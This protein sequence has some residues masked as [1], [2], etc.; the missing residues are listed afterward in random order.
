MSTAT[1]R[2]SESPPRVVRET[3]GTCPVCIEMVDARVIV[4]EGKVFLEKNCP[5]HGIKR[6]FLSN[7]PDYYVE[8]MEAFFELM[9][10]S[11]PQRDYILRL[12]ARCN[13]KCPICLASADDYQERDMT[14]EEVREFIDQPRRLKLDL[15]GAEPTLWPD[16]ETVIRESKEKGH[17]NALHSNGIRLLD[18]DY[19][20]RLIDAGEIGEVQSINLYQS[21]NE[22]SGGGCQGLSVLRLFAA[23]VDWVTGW[24]QGDPTDDGTRTWGATSSSPTA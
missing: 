5:E 3:R 22:I 16:L 11:Y 14:L 21:T 8:L 18:E 6:A 1:Q 17:I 23:D 15:M 10:G 13:M 24:C 9:P 2:A 7:H 19:L 12:T 4:D 20:K